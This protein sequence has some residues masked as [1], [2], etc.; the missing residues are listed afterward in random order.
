MGTLY[1]MGLEDRVDLARTRLDRVITR[2]RSVRE[3][4]NPEA[5]DQVLHVATDEL[6]D[7]TELIGR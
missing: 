6:Q 7:I 4:G 5:L 3:H 2:L 1:L